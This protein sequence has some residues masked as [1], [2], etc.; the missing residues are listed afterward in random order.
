MERLTDRILAVADAHPDATALIFRG[1]RT[2][3]GALAQRARAL[4]AAVQGTAAPVALHATKTPG[5]VA[6][7]LGCLLAGVPYVPIDPSVPAARRELLLRDSG[8]RLLLVDDGAPGVRPPALDG[9]SAAVA[10]PLGR[11][12]KEAPRGPADGEPSGIANIL[13]TSGSTGRPK[14][15]LT[16]HTNAVT[17]LR[18]AQDLIGVR[19]DDVVACYAPLHFDMHVFDL[20]GTL[21]RGAAVLLLDDRTI[22]FPEAVCRVLREEGAT[23]MYAVPSAWIGLLRSASLAEGGLPRLRTLMYSGEEFPVPP[24]RELA[25]LLPQA[26]IVNIYGPV[27]TNAV[28]A[29]AVRPEH[30][31]LDRIPIG[32]PFGDSKVFLIDPAGRVLTEPGAEGEIVVHTATMCEGYLGDPVMTAASRITVE[33]GG[34]TYETYRT[35]DFGTWDAD[36]LLHF[37][38]RRD[39]RIKTR[40][41]RV[42]TGEVEAGLGTH[43]AVEDV[44]V[45]TRPH[46]ERTHELIAFVTLRTPGSLAS[47]ELVAWCRKLLPAYMVP[48]ELRILDGLPRTGTG[49][50]D[51]VALKQLAAVP[52]ER[53]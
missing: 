39:G 12:E 15:V 31:R 23:S 8:A 28:T 7:M 44:V 48:R 29:L 14:G 52:E 5:T 16:T 47:A 11:L 20:F 41:F 43:P 19:A 27:E 33:S 21:S 9:S 34:E 6:A 45:S 26:G 36:G 53:C 38:G 42:E 37:R 24:L 25:A 1:E 49:K 3:Y 46:P 2:G 17:F 22:L 32:L 4:A 50:A 40:G 10:V 13:Y 30:L 35:G 51:R 18:W